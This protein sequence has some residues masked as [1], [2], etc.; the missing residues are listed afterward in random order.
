MTQ[1]GDVF[2][3]TGAGVPL[4]KELAEQLL[5]GAELGPVMDVY[6]NKN[7]I[8]HDEGAIGVFSNGLVNRSTMFE[9][10]MLLLIG[11]FEFAYKPY[12]IVL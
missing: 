5:G 12:N 11:Q 3:A 4:P 6:T 2:T 8:R 7:D 10:I 9:H 1:K